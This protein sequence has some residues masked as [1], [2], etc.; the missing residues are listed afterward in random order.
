MASQSKPP[1]SKFKNILNC[2]NELDSLLKKKKSKNFHKAV[3][4]LEVCVI[5]AISEIAENCLRGNIPLNKCQF[6]KLGKYQDILRKLSAKTPTKDK[7]R[8][9]KEQKGRQLFSIL[10]PSALSFLF[11]V[12]GPYLKKQFTK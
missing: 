11:S 6:K 3:D 2:V 8:I 12:V 10:L 5:K 4:E 7:R 1:T 9:L